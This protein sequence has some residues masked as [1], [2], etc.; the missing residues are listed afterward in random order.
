MSQP[1]DIPAER[2]D[3]RIL[4]SLRRIIHAV[5]QHSKKLK[6]QTDL[7]APQ[8]VCLGQ[9]AAQGPVSVAHL[10]KAVF[11]SASTV[12]GIL[13]RLELKGLVQRARDLKDRRVV[14]VSLTEAGQS[15]AKTAPSPLQDKLSDR[16][17]DL[18]RDQQLAICQSLER[19]VELM[20]ATGIDASPLLITEK[21][22]S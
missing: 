20:E 15:F 2:Y 8:L 13:D 18:Q 19:I 21:K 16:L 17:G 1:T 22:P 6:S 5:D 12:V 14:W 4:Q 7:T 10:A 11:L 3:L 9:I